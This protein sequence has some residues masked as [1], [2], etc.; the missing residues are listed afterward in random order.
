[1]SKPRGVVAFW[2]RYVRYIALIGSSDHA[3]DPSESDG[4]L[5][6]QNRSFGHLHGDFVGRKWMYSSIFRC[7]RK[8]L[9][10]EFLFV[11]DNFCASKMKL[12]KSVH[13]K[14]CT[15][16]AFFLTGNSYMP[17]SMRKVDYS[18]YYR[19]RCCT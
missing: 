11:T 8:L 16:Q 15:M 4:S 18:C 3:I 14:Y 13:I 19:P 10:P 7:F 9:S 17:V 5:F 6:P 2:K 12:N 1:M